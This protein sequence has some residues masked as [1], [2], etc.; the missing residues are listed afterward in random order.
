MAKLSAPGIGL[1]VISALALIADAADAGPA[2]AAKISF[3]RDIRQILSDNCYA[4]HGPDAKQRK[5]ELRLDTKEGAYGKGESGAV[6]I[7]PGELKGSELWLRINSTDSD[8]VMPPPKVKKILT[9]GEIALLKRWIETGAEWEGHWAFT[10][11]KKP[12]P[13]DFEKLTPE[14]ERW[15][16]RPLDRFV[17]DRLQREGLAPS[18]PADLPTLCR[19]LC[20][21][22]T[23]LPPKPE[24]VAA[25]V[26]AATKDRQA[27]VE[28]LVDRLLQ[29][30][31][32]GE[33]MAW[34]WM[35][36]ARYAD[37]NG[38]END[39][40]RTMWPWRDW[41]VK[42]FNENLPYDQ[43]TVWQLAGDLL[44]EATLEQKMATAFLRNH[45]INGEGG[46]IP[47][48][49]RANYVMD[50]TETAGTAWL[51]LTLN[52]CRCH[53]HKFD[54]LTQRDYYSLFAFF[55]QTPV[56][57]S[58]GNPQ[59]PPV[60]EPPDLGAKVMVME[61]RK[62][63]R[64]TFILDKGIYDKPGAEVSA[65][66]PAK[67]TPFPADAPRNRLG[68]AR[69][70][71]APENPLTPRVAANRLW[72][73]F[74]GIGLV[75]TAEDFGVQGELPKH[76]DLLDWLAAGLRDSGWDVKIFV[77]TIVTS[78]TYQQSSRV[79]PALAGRDPENRLL[80]RGPRFRMPAW[81]LLDQ[82]LAV[83]G[84]L[85]NRPGGP[86]VH[87]YQPPGIWEEASFGRKK[88]VQGKGADLYRRSLYTF[89]RRIIGPTMFFDT[90]TRSVCT[91]KPTRTNTPLHALATLN[92]RTYVEAAR[93]LAQGVLQDAKTPEDR[94][95][96]A[97]RRVLMRVPKG[98]EST[99]LLAGLARTKAQFAAHPDDATKL[100]A[101]GASTRDETLDPTE[102]A[103]W[104]AICLAILNFDETLNKE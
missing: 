37:S 104:T 74:F 48:E 26:D 16:K 69:W 61:D 21:D 59:T 12:D 97:F 56:D 50:M 51:G 53:D 52:C 99:V 83:S 38:Y 5:A 101:V 84:L 6:V 60:V 72:Q 65:A 89:W 14:Q 70:M 29:S 73:I 82:A 35:E 43:F 49:N 88:Y 95:T 33:R 64:Q 85:V 2:H 40:D 4:C 23:G 67:L 17:L 103:A 18:P 81:M 46:S 34:D 58:G 45:P 78:A 75:K 44:P 39:K 96:V 10:E 66:T 27:A 41:V 28:A 22:L 9:A 24:D 15:V 63:P 68:L 3:N 25:F 93:T 54:A 94:L 57:G 13:A 76:P 100:L 42:A 11:L 1:I 77:R 92:D 91:V 55:N 30:P 47:E 90:G 79:T 8:E 31:A 98:D 7:K 71:V 19:R 32:F 62:Q 20:L 86:P 36:V 87:P 80:A 102:H